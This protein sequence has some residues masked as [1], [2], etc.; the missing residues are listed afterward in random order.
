MLEFEK[1]IESVQNRIDA[2]QAKPILSIKERQD[3][4]KLESK[5]ERYIQDTY[6][7][8]TAWQK[9]L[10]ARHTGRPQAKDYI[11]RLITRWTP[12][13]GDR[14]FGED[15]AV[16]SGIGFL[17]NTPVMVIGHDK[18]HDTTSRIERNF[19]M[20]YPEGYRKARRLLY[21]A[22]QFQLPVIFLVDT[23]GAYMGAA[24]EERGQ[25]QAIAECIETSLSV[26]IPIL[27]I[28]IG[29]GGSGGAV[30]FASANYIAMLEHSTYSVI[31]PE[32]CASI[33]WRTIEK[34]QEAARAQKL[35]SADL[36][37]LGLIDEIIS[38]PIGGAHRHANETIDR[39]GQTLSIQLKNMHTQSSFAQDRRKK[40]LAMGRVS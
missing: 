21:M 2:L 16:V 20:A 10:V 8:L 5:K 19:G 22:E 34:K 33:L 13:S 14:I 7:R 15:K 6:A 25:S 3:I 12:L 35:T 9:V 31:S 36:K 32:G 4:Q 28:I 39:V 30:A 26:N 17:H 1:K 18:G 37:K 27:S 38:E 29:E 24:A 23:K 40:F 11:A